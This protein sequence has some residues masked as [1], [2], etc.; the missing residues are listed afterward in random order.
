MQQTPQQTR[1]WCLTVNNPLSQIKELP[2]GCRYI[3]SGNE[4]GEEGT[5]HLQIYLEMNRACRFAAIKKLFP[6]A[7]IEVRHGTGKEASDY[8]KKDGDYVEFGE[9]DSVDQPRGKRNDLQAMADMLV[10]GSSLRTVALTAPTTYIRNYRGI[11]HFRNLIY[12]PREYRPDFETWLFVGPTRTGKT[13]FARM[14]LNAWTKPAGK[15]LWFDGYEPQNH[16]IVL[17]DE[18][19]GQYPLTDMLQIC[20]PYLMNVETKGGHVAL[21]CDVI[22]L[23]TNDNPAD[24]YRDHTPDTRKAWMARFTK[25]FYFYSEEKKGLF[26]LLGKED[27]HVY[28]STGQLPLDPKPNYVF[29]QISTPPKVAAI[30]VPPSAPKKPTLKRKASKPLKVVGKG[31]S[32][33]LKYDQKT[34][35]LKKA[36]VQRTIEDCQDS[37]AQPEDLLNRRIVISDTESSFEEYSSI[38][39]TSDEDESSSEYLF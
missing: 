35:K 21:D 2:K 24:M 12:M 33:L 23:A 32:P 16:K 27:H 39:V 36:A 8:C 14:K 18:F 10:D 25:I 29:S 13:F 9:I 34:K 37:Q 5:P 26:H 22:I 6:S 3:V 17:I 19:R 28:L 15:L 11:G 7:H 1:F 31:A 38:S 30:L 4:V 20:D